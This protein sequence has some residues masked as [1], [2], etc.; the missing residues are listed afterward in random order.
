MKI[1]I[2]KENA[3]FRHLPNTSTYFYFLCL[4]AAVRKEWAH[5]CY[6]LFRGTT[7]FFFLSILGAQPIYLDNGKKLS[8]LFEK[9]EIVELLANL[10]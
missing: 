10:R 8:F 4:N 9:E 5:A 7:Y 2:N 3:L 1:F 6:V